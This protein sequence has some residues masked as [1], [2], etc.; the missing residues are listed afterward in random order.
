MSMAETEHTEPPLDPR[1]VVLGERFL[2]WQAI[3]N[4]GRADYAEIKLLTTSFDDATVDSLAPLPED[5]TPVDIETAQRL[6]LHLKEMNGFGED[7]AVIIHVQ[8]DKPVT[9]QIAGNSEIESTILEYV[10]RRFINPPQPE[11]A[12]DNVPGPKAPLRPLGPELV[13]SGDFVRGFVPPDYL[14][15]GIL[16]GTFLYSLT[17]QTGSGKTAVALLLAACVANG[18]EFAGRETRPGRVLYFAGENP[19]DVTMRWIGFCHA[20][21]LDADEMEVY[22]VRGVFSLDTFGSHIAREAD[23]LG[24]VDLVIVDTTA[25]YF[26]GTDENNNVEMGNYARKLR[27][28]TQVAGRPTVIAAS[29]PIKNAG[30]DNLRPRGGS[31]FLNEVDGNLSLARKSADSDRKTSE[32]HWQGKFRGPEFEP[33]AFDLKTINA[34]G[35]V[36]SRNRPIPTVVASPVGLAEVVA[37][38]DLDNR[39]DRQVLLLIQA[40]GSRSQAAM[41]DVLGWVNADGTSN[42]KRVENASNRLKRAQLVEYLTGQWKLTRKGTAAARDAATLEQRE[43]ATRKSVEN[44][45]RN[46]RPKRVPWD[47][48]GADGAEEKKE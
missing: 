11:P 28:L 15:D 42:R 33:M 6:V 38:S 25:A 37:R 10:E 7:N 46:G 17:G 18:A 32:L 48:R 1:A 4:R 27:E 45:I 34:P 30:A 12:N 41:A 2:D 19:D 21:S 35:L 5:D 22:F 24:G 8:D 9:R 14:V 20:H 23:Q 26:E 3:A 40:D 16:Q 39:D 29:H 13:H 31:A 36:D 44:V 43:A 47:R